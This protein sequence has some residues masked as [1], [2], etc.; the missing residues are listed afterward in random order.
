MGYS[1]VTFDEAS[2]FLVPVYRRVWYF[3]G[4]KPE[5]VFFWSNKKIS[6]F[7]ALIDGK[8]LFYEWWDSLNSL[9]Y[10]AFL[11]SFIEQ[12]PKGKYVF[13]LDNAPYHKSS[14]I[15]SYLENLGKNIEVEFFPPYSPELNPNETCWK[16]IRRNVTNSTYYPTIEDMQS[17]INEFLEGHFFMLNLSN[18]LCR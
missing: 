15:M 1:I 2:F 16:I 13:L 18:Y 4:E 7:G 14:V 6:L 8:D 9:T 5:G 11:S 12:L 17:A 10:K 3:K